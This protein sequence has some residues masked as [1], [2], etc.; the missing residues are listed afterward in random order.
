MRSKRRPLLL[1]DFIPPLPYLL[2]KKKKEKSGKFLENLRWK[3]SSLTIESGRGGPSC[4][5]R[6]SHRALDGATRAFLLDPPDPDLGVEPSVYSCL[7]P[8]PGLL[9]SQQL[10]CQEP[11]RPPRTTP[12]GTH[13]GSRSLCLKSCFLA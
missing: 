3:T 2:L 9:T 7:Y 4:R 13:S 5:L 11:A 1:G 8:L 6:L 12:C 10:A